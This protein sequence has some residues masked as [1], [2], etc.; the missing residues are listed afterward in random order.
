MVNTLDP[1]DLNKFI[2]LNPN[3]FSNRKID[4]TIGVSCNWVNSYMK[5]F[6]T[7]NFTYKELLSSGNTPLCELFPSY[8]T[9]YNERHEKLILNF[10]EAIRLGIILVLL[11]YIINRIILNKVEKFQLFSFL[12]S[13]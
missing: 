4:S 6:K 12:N 11:F 8:T 3:G 9:I 13:V 2:N 10:E 1:M 7:S 5:L